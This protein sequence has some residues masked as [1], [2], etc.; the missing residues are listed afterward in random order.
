MGRAASTSTAPRK[1]GSRSR[2][3]APL[4]DVAPAHAVLRIEGDMTVVHAAAQR[5]QILLAVQ[6]A[7]QGLEIDCAAI[8]GIDSAGIQLLLAARHS[9]QGRGAMLR[10]TQVPAAMNDALGVY[11][12]HAVLAEGASE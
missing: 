11:G 9:L 6:S 5:E 7:P 2:K 4:A 1:S 12:L 8:E 10:L 3:A